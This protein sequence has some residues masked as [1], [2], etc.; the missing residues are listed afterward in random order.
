MQLHMEYDTKMIIPRRCLV[1]SIRPLK[2]RD[3]GGEMTGEFC[4]PLRT[5]EGFDRWP[6]SPKQAG[7]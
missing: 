7:N 2:P 3:N 4:G 1:K 5:S 6:Y